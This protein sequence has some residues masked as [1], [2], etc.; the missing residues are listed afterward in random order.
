M[1]ITEALKDRTVSY[2]ERWENGGIAISTKDGHQVVL[3][4]D[5]NGEINLKAVNV[6]ISL[7]R[8]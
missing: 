7:T 6:V 8:M 4:T 1:N 3:E 5:P 2:V